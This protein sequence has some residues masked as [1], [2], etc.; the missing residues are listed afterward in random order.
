MKKKEDNTMLCVVC[1]RKYHMDKSGELVITNRVTFDDD[2]HERTPP[3]MNIKAQLTRQDRYGN[4]GT[5]ASAN[6]SAGAEAEAEKR[7]RDV[8]ATRDAIPVLPPP[9][10]CSPGA[11]REQDPS[12]MLSQK[13]LIGWAMLDKTCDSAICKNQV[14]HSE[15]A[16]S[17]SLLP[18]LA[19]SRP[20]PPLHR[21]GDS[22]VQ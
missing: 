14:H 4:A 18:P 10:A 8:Q 12:A 21:W 6:A 16:L 19:P 17:P 15:A 20:S 7:R 22:E 9:V 11:G 2:A 5:G 1:D 13:L 3:L